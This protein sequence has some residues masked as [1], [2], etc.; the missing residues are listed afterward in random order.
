MNSHPKIRI[1]LADDHL[2]VR[3]GIRQFLDLESDFEIVAEADDG[4][5]AKRLIEEIKPDVAV[6]DIQMP[7]A[8][9]IEV[10][11]H[12]RANH[13]STGVLVLTAYEEDPYI[14]AVL[15]RARMDMFSKLPTQKT[16]FKQSGM[17]MRANLYSIKP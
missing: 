17:F 11:R 9:G 5:Q 8:S 6:L 15:T 2:I 12:I 16:L 14:S 10:T 13:W 4:E 7:K 1:I 3:A